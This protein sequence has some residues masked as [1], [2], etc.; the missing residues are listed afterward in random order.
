M[1]YARCTQG[2]GRAGHGSLA[3]TPIHSFREGSALGPSVGRE[4]LPLSAGSWMPGLWPRRACA[5]APWPWCSVLSS[6]AAPWPYPGLFVHSNSSG[7]PSRIT[8]LSV[9]P[10]SF[11]LLPVLRPQLSPSTKRRLPASSLLI[12]VGACSL[13]PL[14]LHGGRAP[15]HQCQLL[16]SSPSQ[17]TAHRHRGVLLSPSS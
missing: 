7:R 2:P 1:G 15:P 5:A 9:S 4:S 10:P 14:K 8:A 16:P 6:S 17:I 3:P 13:S 12:Q 11:S